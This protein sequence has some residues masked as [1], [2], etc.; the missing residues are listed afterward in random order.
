MEFFYGAAFF[1]FLSITVF[2]PESGWAVAD[3]TPPAPAANLVFTPQGGNTIANFLNSTNTNFTAR[4]EI[5]PGNATGGSAELLLNGEPFATPLKDTEI[6]V[7]DTTV[8]FDPRLENNMELQTL[9]PSG[10]V[11]SVRLADAADNYSDSVEG[12]QPIAVDYI[13]PRVL[14]KNPSDGAAIA[15][16][17]AGDLQYSTLYFVTI[18][19]G[20]Q[21]LNGNP[22]PEDQ[23]W[24][25]TTAAPGE[26]ATVPAIS[27]YGFFILAFAMA[28]AVAISL[29][30]KAASSPFAAE[31]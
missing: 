10:G 26:E 27:S 14:S 16:I 22:V 24:S 5:R 17:P 31:D 4:A 28:T 29:R 3:S 6:G 13:Q 21:D 1:I 8:N 20:A 12:F 19:T 11:L 15:V 30:G 7:A 2:L 9:F 18:T 25:F 23:I